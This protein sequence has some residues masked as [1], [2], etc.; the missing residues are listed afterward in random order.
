MVGKM[1]FKVLKVCPR[2]DVYLVEYVGQCLEIFLVVMTG[3]RY[4][5]FQVERARDTV[6]HPM[7]MRTIQSQ[8]LTLDGAGRKTRSPQSD[9]HT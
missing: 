7:H 2:Q 5:Q 4:W 3:R 1:T 8:V 6:Q 9:K